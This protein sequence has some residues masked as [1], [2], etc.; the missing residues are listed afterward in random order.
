[1]TCF[2]IRAIRKYPEVAHLI[3]A[4]DFG[5]QE[6]DHPPEI[7]LNDRGAFLFVCRDQCRRLA[8][9]QDVSDLLNQHVTLSLWPV[10]ASDVC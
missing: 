8:G 5:L 3:H 2:A 7:G 6:C 4:A 1:M 10:P 9:M